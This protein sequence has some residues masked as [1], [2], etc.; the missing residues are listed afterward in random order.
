MKTAIG[1]QRGAALCTHRLGGSRSSERPAWPRFWSQGQM[2]G[3][4]KGQATWWLVFGTSSQYV[5]AYID[6]CGPQRP[7]LVRRTIVVSP[8]DKVGIKAR[9]TDRYRQVSCKPF[10]RHSIE[11]NAEFLDIG[12]SVNTLIVQYFCNR[13]KEEELV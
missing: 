8:Y 12:V 6:C 10:G 4:P 1:K 5:N 2:C 7:E 9:T 13:S 3:D 11:R